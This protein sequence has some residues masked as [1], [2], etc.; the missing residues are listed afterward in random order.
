MRAELKDPLEFVSRFLSRTHEAFVLLSSSL[1]PLLTFMEY[2]SAKELM[3]E[4]LIATFRTEKPGFDLENLEFK[5][6]LNA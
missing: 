1:R 3:H 4:L 5:N 2:V 6:M